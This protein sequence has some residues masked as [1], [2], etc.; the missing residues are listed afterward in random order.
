MSSS[1]RTFFENNDGNCVTHN[2][3]R[4]IEMIQRKFVF[5]LRRKRDIVMNTNDDY[6]DDELI[7][8]YG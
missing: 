4:Y 6:D 3:E 2:G 8:W 1:G 5:T 7:L